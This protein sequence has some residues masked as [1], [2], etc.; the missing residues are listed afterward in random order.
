MYRRISRNNYDEQNDDAK[1]TRSNTWFSTQ[2]D[3]RPHGTMGNPWQRLRSRSRGLSLAQLVYL[4]PPHPLGRITN[5]RSKP[6]RRET[7]SRRVICFGIQPT[8]FNLYSPLAEQVHQHE[9]LDDCL[10]LVWAISKGT[11]WPHLSGRNKKGQNCHQ[12]ISLVQGEEV[13]QVLVLLINCQFIQ[14]LND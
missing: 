10:L 5:E 7:Y 11:K 3:P 14:P 12:T 6:C 9:C 4:P 2:G 1:K 13:T 8:P